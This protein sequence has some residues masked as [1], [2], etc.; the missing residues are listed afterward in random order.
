MYE[1]LRCVCARAFQRAN[2]VR[3]APAS[4]A[5]G[6][7]VHNYHTLCECVFGVRRACGRISSAVCVW[8]RGIVL[9]VQWC[10]KVRQCCGLLLFVDV[11]VVVEQAVPEGV[12]RLR[13]CIIM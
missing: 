9:R 7:G 11:V 4:V 3:R 10:R 13:G 6:R 8:E 5:A 1:K 2:D 12:A